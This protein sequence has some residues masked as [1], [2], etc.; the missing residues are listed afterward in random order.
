MLYVP[1]HMDYGKRCNMMLF[2]RK[3]SNA[4]QDSG[5][6]GDVDGGNDTKHIQAPD[7]KLA[8]GIISGISQVWI[9]T[10]KYDAGVSAFLKDDGWSQ[11]NTENFQRRQ[12]KGTNPLALC[13]VSS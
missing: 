3:K 10:T 5:A 4:E 9:E 6:G 11:E 12:E 13:L 1:G 8:S 7:S 2:R